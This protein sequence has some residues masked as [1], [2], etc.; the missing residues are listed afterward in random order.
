MS[1]KSTQEFPNNNPFNGPS[2]L[3][4]FL[5]NQKIENLK[6]LLQEKERIILSLKLELENKKF[7]NEESKKL[8]MEIKGN[9][10]VIGR[11]QREFLKNT[12][13]IKNL[14]NENESLRKEI[15]TLFKRICGFEK[16]KEN[17]L[18]NENWQEK[19]LEKDFII[20]GLE[21][22]ALRLFK[23]NLKFALELS[24]MRNRINPLTCENTKLKKELAKRKN[25]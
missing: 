12:K 24:K 21:E 19:S 23:E 14:K 13:E 9:E 11:F 10:N 18:N 7:L 15:L 25:L 22:R 20:K 6:I 3:D 1:I 5:E 8:K 2:N 4:H 17:C 16:S